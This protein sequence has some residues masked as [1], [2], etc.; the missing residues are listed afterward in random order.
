MKTIR[1]DSIGNIGWPS[2]LYTCIELG[3]QSGEYY[4]AGSVILLLEAIRKIASGMGADLLGTTSLMREDMQ[5]IAV[6]TLKRLTRTS[7]GG[8][9]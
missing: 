6:E 7:D 4:K 1:F 9:A 5:S 2:Y 8:P 3:D